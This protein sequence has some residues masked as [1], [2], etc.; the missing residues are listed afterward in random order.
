MDM[1][2]DVIQVVYEDYSDWLSITV[3]CWHCIIDVLDILVAEVSRSNLL[4]YV[5]PLTICH[6]VEA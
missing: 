1:L 6:T 2:R 5:M 4:E 3:T